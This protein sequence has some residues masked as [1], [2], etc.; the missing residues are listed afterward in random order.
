VAKLNVLEGVKIISNL[1]IDKHF[2]NVSWITLVEVNFHLNEIECSVSVQM[3]S[4]C[5]RLRTST[6]DSLICTV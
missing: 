1:I 4:I 6:E 2:E 3:R 5:T